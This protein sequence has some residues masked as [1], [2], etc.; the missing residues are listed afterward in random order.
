MVQTDLAHA[1]ALL[2]SARAYLFDLLGSMWRDAVAGRPI[3]ERDR[4]MVRL[5]ACH[6]ARSAIEA[7]GLAYESAGGA[8][9]PYG[10]RLERCFRDVHVAGQHAMLS[11]QG[12]LEPVGR[13]LLGLSPGTA[14]L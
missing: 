2:G 9:L 14:R 3:T 12:T 13:V 10:S 5:A 6:A 8:A 4:A 1:E 11:R 7:V